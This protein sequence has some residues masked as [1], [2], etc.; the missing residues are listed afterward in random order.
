MSDFDT[1]SLTAVAS[2]AISIASS[3]GLGMRIDP[4]L[5]HSFSV[6]ID[7]LIVGGFTEVSGL[8]ASVQMVNIPDGGQNQYIEQRIGSTRYPTLV[9]KRGIT[10]S[11]ML[12]MWHRNVMSGTIRR[13]NGSVVLMTKNLLELW[14][15]N[16]REAYPIAWNG[17]NLHADAGAV[18][19]ES[20]ELVHRGITKDLSATGLMTAGV[21]IG[22]SG[23]ASFL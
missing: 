2:T 12:W 16:F 8:N 7:G 19:L 5:A 22:I 3:L 1:G 20:I 15:W 6:E 21:S 4:A 17:P 23:S 14:R 9:L 13:R 11:D 18:A 10:T